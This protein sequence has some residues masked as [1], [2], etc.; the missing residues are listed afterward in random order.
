MANRQIAARKEATYAEA[1]AASA[2]SASLLSETLQKNIAFEDIA[3]SRAN[4]I[5][6]SN[7]LSENQ[8]GDIELVGSYNDEVGIFLLGFFGSHSISGTFVHKFPAST[9]T[10]GRTGVSLGVE[11]KRDSATLS[12]RYIGVKVIGMRYSA[13]LSQSPQW[14]FSLI[15]KDVTTG[16]ASSPTIPGFVPITIKDTTVSFDGGATQAKVQ[17]VSITASWPVDEPHVMGDS[18]FALEPIDS[19]FLT[20]E[21]EAT[22]I[23]EDLDDFALFD[24]E[25]NI[26]IIVKSTN[27]SEIITF[28]MKKSR[29]ASYAWNISGKDR[30]LAS[31]AWKSIFNITAEENLLVTITNDDSTDYGT[32]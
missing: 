17:S 16:A 5:L 29:F 23:L 2:L 22:I 27:G 11:I 19:D 30:L 18:L 12:A 15:G 20:V 28:E 14:G 31:V 21:G 7:I 24:G 13:S 6:A 25:T 1:A 32:L 9:G 4:S 8:G 3:P 26:D 10:S